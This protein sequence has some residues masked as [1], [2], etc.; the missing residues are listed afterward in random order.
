MFFNTFVLNSYYSE[1]MSYDQISQFDEICIS[2][3]KRLDR[4]RV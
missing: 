3:E 1:K 2:R 4:L